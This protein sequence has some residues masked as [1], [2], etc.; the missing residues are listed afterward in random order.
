MAV[1][2]RVATL[3]ATEGTQVHSLYLSLYLII[4]ILYMI[5]LGYAAGCEPCQS[6]TESQRWW[7]R[8]TSSLSIYN[9][10]IINYNEPAP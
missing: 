7:R 3:V 1:Y 5:A 2:D 6:T 8:Y 9:D 10:V 4:Y